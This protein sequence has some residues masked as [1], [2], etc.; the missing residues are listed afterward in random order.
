MGEVAIN[1]EL[2]RGKIMKALGNSGKELG[3]EPEELGANE[4]F[5]VSR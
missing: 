3:L 1:V 2:S 5:E 4:E